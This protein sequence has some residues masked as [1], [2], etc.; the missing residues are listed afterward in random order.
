MISIVMTIFNKGRILKEILES[1]FQMTSNMV[2][3]YIFILDG[4]NDNSEKILMDVLINQ[5]DVKYKLFFTDNVFEIR[6]NNIGLKNVTNEYVIIIQDDMLIKEKDYDLRLLKPIIKYKDIWAVTARTS[7]SLSVNGIWYN[8][9]EGPVGHNYKDNHNY[10]RNEIY[11][12]Q[13]INRGPL[14]MNMKIVKEMGYFDETLP[15]VIGCDDTDLCLKVYK[16]YNLR[17]ASFFISYYSP[18]EWG[19]TRTGPNV[20]FCSDQQMLNLK[21]VIK[22]YYDIISNWN[23]DEI[24]YIE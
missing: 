24:R 18:L 6:A 10:P 1:L 13:I 12:G 11:V 15:G 7:C 23:N 5:G 20:N 8:I 14:L 9:K 19:S 21:E 22:R 17:C 2:N 16:T 3:E 4:C